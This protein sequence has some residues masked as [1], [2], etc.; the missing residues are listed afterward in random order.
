MES[1]NVNRFGNWKLFGYPKEISACLDGN[2]NTLISFEIHLTN[3]CQS[4]CPRCFCGHLR[5]NQSLA[6]QEACSFMQQAKKLGAKSVIFSGGG[7]P[8]LHSDFVEV[9]AQAKG[10]GFKI[11]VNTNGLSL[12][13]I[14][15]DTLVKIA[16]YIRISLDAGTPEMY[17]ITHGLDDSD[18]QSVLVNL[19]LLSEAKRRNSVECVLGTGYLTDERTVIYREMEAFVEVS[20]EAGFD[21]AQFRPFQGN[22]TPIEPCFTKLESKFGDD[23]AVVASAQKYGRFDDLNHRPY[24]KC[25]SHNFVTIIGADAK[26]YPCCELTLDPRYA[27]GDLRQDELE[28]I[29]QKKEEVIGQIDLSKCNPFCRGDMINRAMEHIVGLRANLHSD[30]L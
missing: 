24:E 13:K 23:I 6:K 9:A 15:L 3:K 4:R 12:H 25:W 20:A 30:F 22:F 19:K 21:F 17:N 26:L 2:L 10:M 28:K 16:S 11:G 8:A 18:F 7:E 29:W 1:L 27:L 14:D 5:G